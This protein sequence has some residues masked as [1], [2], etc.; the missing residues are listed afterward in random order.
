VSALAGAEN[1]N[2]GRDLLVEAFRSYLRL[3]SALALAARI[4]YGAG[5]SLGKKKDQAAP[6]LLKLRKRGLTD[7]EWVG[8]AR[9]LLRPWARAPEEHALPEL[10][11]LFHK[12][13]AF[14]KNIDALLGLRRKATVAHGTTGDE[15]AA[16]EV[17]AENVRHLAALLEMS[18]RLWRRMRLVATLG[19]P[20]GSEERQ[21][22]YALTGCTPPRRRWR[23]TELATGTDLQPGTVV[24][25]D[26]QGEAR[27]SLEPVGLF[28]SPSPDSPEELFLFDGP[29]GKNPLYVAFP[30]MAEH[31]QRE[32]WEV[33]DSAL[34]G[35]SEDYDDESTTGVD[36]P[37]R[38]LESFRQEHAVLF[39]GR[40]E[41]IEELANR[42]RA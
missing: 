33:L 37:F 35:Q 24:A 27:L 36:R 39:C 19:R 38:G 25:I 2:Q 18:D 40:E 21:R 26:E 11:E 17:L 10:V 20:D 42:V 5:P 29:K 16:R 30:S 1:P 28:R 8:L 4:Q 31:R 13:R 22:A 9:E 14:A 41:L 15:Q 7:G 3:L 12:K 23:R 34:L 32:M 6:I